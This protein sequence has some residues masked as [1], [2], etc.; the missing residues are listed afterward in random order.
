M[1]RL[2]NLYEHYDDRISFS[3]EIITCPDDELNA[4]FCADRDLI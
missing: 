1:Y 3:I 2:K 4:D